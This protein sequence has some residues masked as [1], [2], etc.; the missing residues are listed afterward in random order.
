MIRYRPQRGGFAESMR[1]LV[2]LPDA[3]SVIQHIRQIWPEFPDALV[4]YEPYG[5]DKRRGW[6]SATYLVMLNGIGIGFADKPLD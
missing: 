6:N 2:T 4:T 1:E 5:I 3:A